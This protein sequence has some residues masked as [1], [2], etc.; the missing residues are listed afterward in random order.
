MTAT[1][2]R[3]IIQPPPNMIAVQVIG[4]QEVAKDAISL[5]L[6]VP[7]TQRPPSGYYPGQF[8]TLAIPTPTEILYRSYS[9]CGRGSANEPWEITIKRVHKGRISN[10]L[11]DMVPVGSVLYVS[12]PRGTFT[13]PA[14]LRRDVPL[15]FV[16]AGSGVTPIRGMLRALARVPAG[17]RPQA[18]LHYASRTPEDIIYRQ[19]L[20]QIDPQMAWLKQY[21]YLSSMGKTLTAAEVAAAAGPLARRAHWYICGPDALRDAMQA[22]LTQQGVPPPQQHVEVFATQR[23][24]ATGIFSLAAG[25]R[26][27]PVAQMTIQETQAV[28]DVRANETVLDALE[29]QGYRPESSCRAGT[30]GTCKLRLLAGRVDQTGAVALTHAERASGYFLSC[31]AKPHGDITLLSGGRVSARHGA[32]RTARGAQRALTRAACVAAV[33]VLL[34]GTWQLTDHRPAS[35][36]TASAASSSAT[37]TPLPGGSAPTDTP[38]PP[39]DTPAPTSTPV[40]GGN[41][42]PAPTAA[43]APPTATPIPPPPTATP[44]PQPPPQPT[45]VTGPSQG[46]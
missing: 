21:H 44:V 38:V 26:G 16:A 15:I 22:M 28:L 8:V 31:V 9:L 12:M 5:F 23:K 1:G 32:V 13:L 24:P 40:F 17:Q 3:P 33:S 4:R 18:Q 37:A 34:F 30:C 45:V 19:E 29:R 11:C 25:G 42:G 2:K 20:T 7:G 43:P 39:T 6:A 10:Y 27:H 36:G 14:P 46:G 41:P 35:W